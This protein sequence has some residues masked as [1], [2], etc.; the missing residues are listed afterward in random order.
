MIARELS[1]AHPGAVPLYTGL[2]FHAQSGDLVALTGPSGSGKSTLLSLLG[3]WLSPTSGNLEISG[4]GKISLVPQNPFGVSG[5]SLL[6]HVCLPLLAKGLRRAEAEESAI[7]KIRLV[8][9]SEIADR[10]YR[11]LS[12]GERQRMLLARAL[13]SDPGMLL[14]DEPTAQLDVSAASEVCE[15]LSHLGERGVVVFVATHD[16]RVVNSCSKVVDLLP[17]VPVP[18]QG[19]A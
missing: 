11:M 10:P 5:R 1:F 16:S 6:D 18:V 7:E 15:V 9:L 4:E 12:G 3:G 19:E 14:V 13:A 17:A 2:N 8:K